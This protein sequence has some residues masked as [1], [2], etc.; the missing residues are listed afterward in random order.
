[1]WAAADEV[2]AHLADP[3]GA[4][5]HVRCCCH[6]GRSLQG[7]HQSCCHLCGVQQGRERSIATLHHMQPPYPD[8]EAVHIYRCG[9]ILDEVQE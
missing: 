8:P 6:A 7:V 2:A 5:C 4:V 9:W 1:M 3:A